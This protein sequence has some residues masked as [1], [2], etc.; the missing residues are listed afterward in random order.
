MILAAYQAAVECRGTFA[1]R[2]SCST[3]MDD[4]ETTQE[5]VT[6]APSGDPAAQVPL[7]VVMRA[8]KQYLRHYC[9]I[10]GC[11]FVGDGRSAARILGKSDTTSWYRIWE[12]VTA[13]YSVCARQGKG[14]IVRGL[15]MLEAFFSLA[16]KKR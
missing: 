11:Y 1:P 2:E 13:V 8:S 3:I 10:L 4:M 5:S 12:A 15:G 7:P 6:F 14:G 9:A 16:E